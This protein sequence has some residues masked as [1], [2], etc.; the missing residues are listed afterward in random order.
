[1]VSRALALVLMI[2]LSSVGILIGLLIY[3][4]SGKP[5]LGMIN[6]KGGEIIKEANVGLTCA[7]GDFYG[8]SNNILEMSKMS[9]TELDKLG[10]NLYNY[11]KRH[12]D[13]SSLFNKD[14][15]IILSLLK[16]VIIK[17]LGKEIKWIF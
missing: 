7:S 14:D 12:L 4:S 2:V 5:I 17:L 1:M 9:Y 6:G 15:E 3:I 11:Y 16:W 8:L 13:R 10:N